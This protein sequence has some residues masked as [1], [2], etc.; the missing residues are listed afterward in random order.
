MVIRFLI[1]FG[2]STFVKSVYHSTVGPLRELSPRAVV[3]SI[4]S[5]RRTVKSLN[6]TITP[7]F[8]LEILALPVFLVHQIG[9]RNLPP[10][11]PDESLYFRYIS[12]A[13]LTPLWIL[14]V[15]AAM[16]LFMFGA[17]VD[18]FGRNLK[19][20][21]RRQ[22]KAS[23]W[24]QLDVER[25]GAWQPDSATSSSIED[26]TKLPGAWGSAKV[27]DDLRRDQEALIREKDNFDSEKTAWKQ[28]CA[29]TKEEKRAFEQEKQRLREEQ[30]VFQQ[31]Q[32]RWKEEREAAAE[33]KREVE[34]ILRSFIEKSKK[35]GM[36]I[37]GMK[38][39][40]EMKQMMLGNPTPP[41]S[42][43]SERATTAMPASTYGS[44]KRRTRV[45]A[46]TMI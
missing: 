1:L 3:P 43:K 6:R 31:Q 41:A 21:F 4:Y 42:P 2:T 26:M 12:I 44:N 7:I 20:M 19:R 23:G 16:V 13:A 29:R 37:A 33:A 15:A 18:F 46:A 39:G 11:K 10:R 5:F 17:V 24:H 30:A 25:G 38:R 45:Q 35:S 8:L 36:V 9:Y 27:W 22:P 40:I 14:A 34:M 32:Q 28:E